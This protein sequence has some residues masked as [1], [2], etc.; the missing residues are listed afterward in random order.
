MGLLPWSGPDGGSSGEP[1][2]RRAGGGSPHLGSPS[3]MRRGVEPAFVASWHDR[4]CGSARARSDQRGR[5]TRR[6]GVPAQPPQLPDSAER[7]GARWSCRRGR[8]R[9]PTTASCCATDGD[10]GRAC[11]S[12]ST[13]SARS[14]AGPSS[15]CNLGAWCVLE[16][17]RAHGVRLLRALLRQRGYHF[18]DLSPSGNVV[19]LNR[20]LELPATSTRRP[21]WCP[22]CRWPSG[23]GVARRSPT[24]R[25]STALLTGADRQI[26]DDHAAAAAAR[27]LVL[28]RRRTSTATS[29]SAATG[30]RAC[31]CSPRCCTSATPTLFARHGELGVQPPAAPPRRAGHAGRAAASWATAAGVLAVLSSA[32]AQDVPQHG[33]WPPDDIDYL[34]SELTC[35]AW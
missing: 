18:T 26:F 6:R 29:S 11:T 25:A 10:R 2:A 34:Y 12:P 14:T 30:A 21:R 17:H 13:P 1:Y 28:Q 16:P 23:S 33:R 3:G 20:R 35:V 9:R 32:A 15:F 22:T 19:A 7:L 4:P 8:P 24:P 27:H 5:R 31:R